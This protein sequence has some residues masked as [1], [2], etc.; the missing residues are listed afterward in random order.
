MSAESDVGCA[1]MQDICVCGQA[2]AV[3]HRYSLSLHQHEVMAEGVFLRR[4]GSQLDVSDN[5]LSGFM[6]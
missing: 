5:V 3:L 6:Q 2:L 1:I 4:A